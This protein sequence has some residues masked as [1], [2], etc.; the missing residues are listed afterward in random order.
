MN[1][2][3]NILIIGLGSMGQRR[4]RCFK[5]LGY[6]NNNIFGFDVRS[7]RIN[8][9]VS[10]Y[11]IKAYDNIDKCLIENTIDIFIIS[12]PPKLH[13]IYIN[14]AIFLKK[15]YF[16]EASIFNDDY[17]KFI[18]DTY[19]NDLIGM[20][21]STLTNHGAIDKIKEIIQ[22]GTLGKLSNVIYHVGQYLPNWHTYE[23]VSDF[24]VSDPIQGGCREI[25]PFELTWLTKIFGFPK[26]VI[27]SVA[28][29]ID[30]EGA[31]EIDDTYNVIMNYD[32]YMMTFT[33]DVVSRNATRRLVINGSKGQLIWD[34]N[35]NGIIKLYTD[36]NTIDI[37]IDYNMNAMVG[38]NKNIAE[39]MYIDEMQHLINAVNK[40]EK[41]INTMEYDDS[42]LQLLYTIEKSS[43]CSSKIDNFTKT[44][45]LINIRLNSERLKKK[46]LLKI[47]DYTFL[48]ILVK[49][50]QYGFKHLI[51]ENN[52]KIIIAS[53][54]LELNKELIPYAKKLNIE[55]FFGD[56]ENIPQRHLECAS[57]YGLTHIIT[58]DGDDPLCSIQ[59]SLD[60]YNSFKTHDIIKTDGL[61]LGM[62]SCGYNVSY[63]K[64]C[65]DIINK[66]STFTGELSINWHSIFN[67]KD[68]FDLKYTLFENSEI[69][70]I[71]CTLDYEI[72]FLFFKKVVILHN[73]NIFDI[74]DYFLIKSIIDE[75]FFEINESITDEYWRN[76]KMEIAKNK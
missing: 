28:K 3:N 13:N 62:N 54:D 75:K 14:K 71:R 52:V 7:D 47:N 5:S 22:N 4:I 24:Y 30:I 72:D 64:K 53:S 43:K 42:V 76:F 45:I 35:D 69:N 11:E 68:I 27:G 15:H 63:L 16:V 34:W 9:A 40:N 36:N 19:N 17:N 37:N 66:D 44:G 65:L 58:I 74:S 29:T 25:V 26:S 55:V 39:Q 33:I 60:I 31:L 2:I 32:N 10:K 23:K 49:R 12:V 56:N 48:E 57:Y 67:K 61:P 70:K 21:S 1:N 50:F 38:Y 59:G 6:S 20:P 18:I 51:L 41:L 8:N 46:H 73:N